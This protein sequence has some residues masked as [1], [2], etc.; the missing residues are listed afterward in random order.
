MELICSNS[1]HPEKVDTH[2]NSAMRL[3]SGVVQ[4]TLIP[5]LPVLSN[6]APPEIRRN[7]TLVILF[8]K[9]DAYK[10]SILYKYLEHM[11]DIGL[12]SRKPPW[13]ENCFSRSSAVLKNGRRSGWAI[14]HYIQI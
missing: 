12:K 11:P 6:I 3:I 10:S 8:I 2:I 13:P 4:S 1:A 14:R 9:T 5:W 7:E